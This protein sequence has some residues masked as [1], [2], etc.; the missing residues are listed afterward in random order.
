MLRSQG[1]WREW[2]AGESGL[3]ALLG[4]LNF[5]TLVS[6]LEEELGFAAHREECLKGKTALCIA[7]K[8]ASKL[9]GVA[10]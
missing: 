8:G 6:V 7:S 2:N 3:R 4:G 1:R 10:T 9:S 5:S